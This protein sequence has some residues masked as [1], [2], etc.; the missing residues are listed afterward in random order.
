LNG[1]F[2][3]TNL[4]QIPLCVDLDGTL[5]RTDT[6]LEQL[7]WILRKRPLKLFSI[8]L[9]LFKGRVAMKKKVFEIS[10]FLPIHIPYNSKLLDAL[11][12]DHQEGRSIYLVTG[13]HLSFAQKVA[14]HL[15]IFKAVHATKDTNLVG[16][17]K[18]KSLVHHFGEN[19]FD[20]IGNSSVDIPIWKKSRKGILVKKNPLLLRRAQKVANVESQFVENEK[21]LIVNIIKQIR[22]HQWAK[23]ILIFLP[24]VLSHTYNNMNIWL[25]CISAMLSFACLSSC[26]YLI[27]DVLDLEADRLHPENKDRPF[28]SGSLSLVWLFILL[29]CLLLTSFLLALSLRSDFLWV[30][31]GYFIL[32]SVY[33]IKLKKMPIADILMLA[34]L[35]AW[36]V[37]AGS[38]ATGI[39]LSN[40]FL[41]FSIFFFFSLALVKRCAELQLLRGTTGSHNSRRGYK[42]DD[43]VLLQTFGVASGYLS[44]LVL[45]LYLNDPLLTQQKLYPGLLWL[46]CPLLLYWLSRLWLAAF[47][48]KI[49][50]DPMLF[51]LKDNQSY[52]IIVL[53]SL[54]WLVS[55]GF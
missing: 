9:A 15:K 49:P 20:Y 40:W 47:R 5:S 46:I 7:F 25:T 1:E 51:A 12:I 19:Q 8:A 26:V 48:G 35:Y 11:K 42:L 3:K 54:L 17:E 32:T 24:M 30:L 13:S 33:S 41:T 10:E 28:A 29:P 36:R 50:S 23:N 45:A 16:R 38:V 18:A 2:S 44:V 4:Q 37:F 53:I 6:L 22:V 43:I 21:S 27:N 34:L 55:K 31:G 52:F 14:D 39:S